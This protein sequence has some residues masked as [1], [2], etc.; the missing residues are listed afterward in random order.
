MD[1]LLGGMRRSAI[2][3]LAVASA[4]CS[5]F[6]DL[7]PLAVVDWSPR[8]ETLDPAAIASLWVEFSEEPERTKAESAFSLT[9]DGAKMQGRYSWSGARLVFD[10]LVPISK[11]HDYLLSVESSAETAEGKSLER[12]FCHGFTTK[13]ERGRPRI[14]SILPADGAA[15]SD[16]FAPVVIGFSEAI[17]R[18]S[19]LSSFSLSPDPG[20]RI[21]F[22][23]GDS[24]ATFSPLVPWQ[25]GAE[26][27]IAIG[28]KVRDLSGNYI[29]ESETCV[30]RM[31]SERLAPFVARVENLVDGLPGGIVAAAEDPSDADLEINP[32]WESG[33]GVRIEFSE[34]V[35]REGIESYFAF[36][37]G[38]DF[39]M[40]TSGG[41]RSVFLLLPEGAF[42]WGEL[43][44]LTIKRGIKDPSGNASA[45]DAVY[46][47]RVDGSASR[48]CSVERVDFRTNP[49]HTP[50][51]LESYDE[52]DAFANFPLAV[53]EYPV[54]TAVAT[55]LD[56][57]VRCASG[58]GIDR[59]SLMSAFSV[60]TTN[61]AA[62]IKAV[63]VSTSGFA[64]PQPDCP[65]GLIPA[66]IGLS[67][68]NTTNSGIVTLR[69]DKGLADDRGTTAQDV[70]EL[71]LV[72]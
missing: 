8:S 65:A 20:G 27:K 57:F 26:Y 45:A 23:S 9:E 11:G 38:W 35:E 16:G 31:G 15:I 30:F 24:V 72:K 12:D 58:A 67:I 28:D 64:D 37:P 36:E 2:I 6:M 40:D 42:E 46:N 21:T 33:W 63:S 7:K 61:G 19:F 62:I 59:L 34:P 5:L 4:S 3:L 56:V 71:P 44:S 69:I 14:V 52:G 22:S 70:F 13:A 50:A 49:L 48:P 29:A 55:Y 32:G 17:S 66:R 25:A 39:S 1:L 47:L 68:E 43:Y 51:S 10:P 54:G 60:S 18:E 53:A 41:A